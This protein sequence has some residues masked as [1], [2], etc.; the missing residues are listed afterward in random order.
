M[1]WY[2]TVFNE[3]VD[4]D[5][6]PPDHLALVGRFLTLRH[7]SIAKL[8]KQ[9]AQDPSAPSDKRRNCARQTALEYCSE[10]R[11]L[12][13]QDRLSG[14]AYAQVINGPVGTLLRD[15]FYRVYAVALGE[16]E[17]K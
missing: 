4:L 12:I 10:A 7:A 5:G 6:L 13:A 8:Q 11:A 17:R 3:G 15:G 14:G 9:L 2:R 16:E 1:N